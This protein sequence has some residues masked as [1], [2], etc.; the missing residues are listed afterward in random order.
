MSTVL[1]ELLDSSRAGSSTNL[2]FSN[3]R[4]PGCRF[5]I[6]A[7]DRLAGGR[8]REEPGTALGGGPGGCWDAVRARR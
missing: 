2:P 1:S 7:F 3:L 4:R 6:I 5:L 8:A